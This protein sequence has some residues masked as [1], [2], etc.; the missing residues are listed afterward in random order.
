[1]KS[2]ISIFCI[3]HLMVQIN[4]QNVITLDGTPGTRVF[5][6]IDSALKYAV[7]GDDLYL[8]GGNI[9]VPNGLNIKKRI[10]VF[11][12]GHYPDSTIATGRTNIVGDVIFY[13]ESSG[14]VL[15]GVYITGD[16]NFGTSSTNA[17][18]KNIRISRCNVTN[19]QLSENGSSFRGAENVFIKDNV[20]RGE[21]RFAYV[22]NVVFETNCMVGQ[23]QYAD[24]ITYIRNN[25]FMRG[26]NYTLSNVK[27]CRFENNIFLISSQF[28]NGDC[29]GNLFYNNVFKEGDPL[30]GQ[31]SSNNLFNVANL[32]V[33]QAGMVF[34][35]FQDYHLTNDSPARNAG[36]GG[37]DCGIYGGANPYKEGA[38]PVNPHIRSSVLP[39][40]TD[41]L[42]K[43]NI[44][45]KVAAQNN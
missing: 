30:A 23:L 36:M 3:I 34:S 27:Y 24:G 4:A 25:I 2:L 31:Y 15:E 18:A 38:L 43:L 39:A 32:F 16:I 11:G 20:I 9:S 8:H 37:T 28:L 26:N 45:V 42:G 29:P 6:N 41:T 19:I 33:S 17:A 14:S 35:Y 5:A 13:N 12:A 1:M 44:Q 22:K 10:H 21:M 40:Q 7:D